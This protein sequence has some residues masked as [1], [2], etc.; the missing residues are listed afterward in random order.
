MNLCYSDCIKGAPPTQGGAIAYVSRSDRRPMGYSSSFVAAPKTDWTSSSQRP[1]NFQWHLLC[2]SNRLSVVRSSGTIRKSSYLPSPFESMDEQW[3]VGTPVADDAHHAQP[4][5]Q[6]P[7]GTNHSGC[8][9]RSSEKR[10][11]EVGTAG[12]VR[13][14]G[15]KRSLIVDACGVPLALTSM[16]ASHHDLIGA[17]PTLDR[18]HVGRRRRPG[19]LIADKGYDSRTFRAVL[20]ERQIRSHIPVRNFVG[21]C[22]KRGRPFLVD[23]A[24]IAQRWVVER[25]FGWLNNSFRRLR[26]RYERL[27]IATKLFARWDVF[28]SA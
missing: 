15:T 27:L 10:G 16:A 26:I 1:Q 13:I 9:P 3:N 12:K 24:K 6:A 28:S 2:S 25:T 17:V 22:R 7:A 19:C 11:S 5:R 4:P 23:R 18:L 8:Q 21:R 14:D 20:Q